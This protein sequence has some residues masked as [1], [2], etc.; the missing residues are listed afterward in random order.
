[1]KEVVNATSKRTV[2]K[3]K[4][5]RSMK[6]TGLCSKL[7]TIVITSLF[8][9]PLILG[10]HIENVNIGGYFFRL[11]EDETYTV[12]AEE[13][14]QLVYNYMRDTTYGGYFQEVSQNWTVVTNT[15]KGFLGNAFIARGF[16]QLYERTKNVTYLSWAE[17]I[18]STLWK[19]CWDQNGQLGFFDGYFQNW[20]RNTNSQTLQEQAEFVYIALGVYNYTS[21]ST[22]YRWADQTMHFIMD[23]YHDHT[24]GA[25]YRTRNGITGTIS[26]TNKQIEVSLGAFAWAA[27]KWYE[28]TSNQTALTYSQECVNW[29]RNHLWNATSSGYMTETNSVGLVINKYYYPNV[30]MWGIVGMLEYHRHTSNSTVASWIRDGLNHINNTMWD[31]T[32]GGWYRK[33][34]PDNSTLQDTKTGWDN[35]EQPWFWHYVYGVTNNISD[36]NTAI[37]SLNW[38]RDHIW[39]SAHKGFWLELTRDGTMVTFETKNDWVHGGAVVAFAYRRIHEISVN[40]ISLSKATVGQGYNVHINVTATNEGD[41]TE[42]FNVASYA[43]TTL[44]QEREIVIPSKASL[45]ITF[46]WNTTSWAYGNYTISAHAYPVPYEADT[47]DNTYTDG[48]IW[49][50]MPGD[51]NADRIVN[52]LDAGAISAHWYPGPPYGPLDYDP[53]F[54][55]NSDGKINILEISIVSAYWT[56]PPKGPLDP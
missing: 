21:N 50:V 4:N 33:L 29:I 28:Y 54:D 3:M 30:E 24:N 20:T 16:L 7:V 39:D 55:I 25:M 11:E 9:P 1:M 37:R 5:Q 41:F 17:N 38:T 51:V 48:I 44:L 43:N 42:T 36:K 53:N 26:N 15:H 34:N 2:I 52:I 14:A 18:V 19:K 12:Y 23:N 32:Y 6:R 13:T 47:G 27:M 22:Y 8:L 10:A 56:G 49:V 31:R 35:A 45:T 46:V 40:N